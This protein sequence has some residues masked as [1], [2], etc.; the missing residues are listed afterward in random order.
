MTNPLLKVTCI[1]ILVAFIVAG[2]TYR[3]PDPAPA[4]YQPADIGITDARA[5]QLPGA[6]AIAITGGLTGGA[7]GYRIARRNRR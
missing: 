4:S 7:I 5:D 2:V 3:D 1:A 6:L